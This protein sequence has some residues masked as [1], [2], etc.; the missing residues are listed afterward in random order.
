MAT[1]GKP[2]SGVGEYC[3]SDLCLLANTNGHVAADSWTAAMLISIRGVNLTPTSP[4][5]T[6][7]LLWSHT[8]DVKP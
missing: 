6:Q 3:V 4:L 8:P 5:L 1:V 7:P 2:T